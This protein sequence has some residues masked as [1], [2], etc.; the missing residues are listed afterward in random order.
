MTSTL[1]FP[2]DANQKAMAMLYKSQT[3]FKEISIV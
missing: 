3:I 1:P 2:R